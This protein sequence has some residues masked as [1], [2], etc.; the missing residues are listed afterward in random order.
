MCTTDWRGYLRYK[1][2]Y[3]TPVFVNYERV[4]FDIV[5][6]DIKKKNVDGDG[7]VEYL[8]LRKRII[9]KKDNKIVGKK[10]QIL[11]T[12]GVGLFWGQHL[13]WKLNRNAKRNET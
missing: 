3:F 6:V 7:C 9:G 12:A 13:M 8:I 10:P 2:K 5:G 4:I 11:L 1:K